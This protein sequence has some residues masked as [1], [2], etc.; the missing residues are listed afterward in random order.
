MIPWC[1]CLC[2]R[3]FW[4]ACRLT[5]CALLLCLVPGVVQVST[6]PTCE[7]RKERLGRFPRS[8]TN[9]WFAVRAVVTQRVGL[10]FQQVYSEREAWHKI[11][12]RQY[13]YF[14][15]CDR[16]WFKPLRACSWREGISECSYSGKNSLGTRKITPREQEKVLKYA[17]F[18]HKIIERRSGTCL[19]FPAAIDKKMY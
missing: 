4:M 14:Y 11:H 13:K 1:H 2:P 5:Y 18:F 17:S 6:A 3:R 10:V 15:N 19:C 8:S 16:N 7:A 12:C 9:C